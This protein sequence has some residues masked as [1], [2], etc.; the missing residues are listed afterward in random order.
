MC[1]VAEHIHINNAG[2][3]SYAYDPTRTTTLRNAFARDMRV[4]FTELM[5]VIKIGVVDNDCFGLTTVTI[6]QMSPPWERQFD[7]QTDAEKIVAFMVWLRTQIDLGIL[8]EAPWMNLYLEDAYKRGVLRARYELRKAGY[9]V[10]QVDPLTGVEGVIS[11]PMHAATLGLVFVMASEALKGVTVSMETQISRVLARGLS[12]GDSAKVL[13]SKL[14]S[15]ISGR[16]M[17]TLAITDTLGRFIPAKRRAEMIART[18]IVRAHHL[19]T[20]QTYENWGAMGV[21]VHAE[22]VTAG[23]NR[24][25]ADCEGMEGELFTLSAIKNMIPLHPQCRCIALPYIIK[26]NP[27][28]IIV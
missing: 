11:M 10:P 25:C 23:D 14:L 19:A 9:N 5:K 15:A 3:T 4:R 16:N 28:N 8:T 12:E 17:G 21:Y 7:L 20:I 24:V 26:G 22:W 2:F 13:A 27:K 18:E 1:E 6:N